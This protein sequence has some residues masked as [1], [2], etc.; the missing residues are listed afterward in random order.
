MKA[1]FISLAL[2]LGLGPANGLAQSPAASYPDQQQIDRDRATQPQQDRDDRQDRDD[3]SRRGNDSHASA[4]KVQRMLRE[5]VPNSNIAVNMR[6]RNTVVLSGTAANDRDRQYADQLVR[7]QY[8]NVR[9]IDQVTVNGYANGSGYPNGGYSNTDRDR[10][11]GYNRQGESDRDRNTGYNRSDRENGYNQSDRDRDQ[12][13]VD[14][15]RMPQTDAD[16]NRDRDRDQDRKTSD[17]DKK[18]K[19]DKDKYKKDKDKDDRKDQD[20]DRSNPPQ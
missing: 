19:K 9:V 14:R 8:G 10:D 3:Q 12:Q 16:A 2:V 17:N 7:S 11:N 15:D 13:N 18:H 1:K 5:R 4:D 20:K 6:D